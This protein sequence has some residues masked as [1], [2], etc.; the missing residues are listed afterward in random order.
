[1]RARCGNMRM[2]RRILFAFLLVA[3][4]LPSWPAGAENEDLQQKADAIFTGVTQSNDPGM[5]VLV[6]KN[7]HTEFEKSY[8]V[9]DLRTRAKIDGKTNFRLSLIHI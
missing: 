9:A 1:M 8:G 7:G 6:L 5:A 2:N 3:G 4:L